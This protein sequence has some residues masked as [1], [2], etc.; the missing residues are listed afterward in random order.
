MVLSQRSATQ[1]KRRTFLLTS[2]EVSWLYDKG[3]AVRGSQF[4]L[5]NVVPT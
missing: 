2:L 3:M 5:C 1:L 4:R